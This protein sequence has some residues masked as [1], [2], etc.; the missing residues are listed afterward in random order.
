MLNAQDLQ[1]ETA[2][3]LA[4]KKRYFPRVQ[5]LIKTY[6]AGSKMLI[7]NIH[8]VESS[9]CLLDVQNMLALYPSPS[10]AK[11]VCQWEGPTWVG[12]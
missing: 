10:H 11:I 2:L 4:M 7:H 3:H 8:C 6:E 9:K 1:E 5:T 12:G